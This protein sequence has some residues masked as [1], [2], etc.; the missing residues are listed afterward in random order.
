LISDQLIISIFSRNESR[1]LC[2]GKLTLHEG[3]L[4]VALKILHAKSLRKKKY[5]NFPTGNSIF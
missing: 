1:A 3:V 2:S 4:A 5:S